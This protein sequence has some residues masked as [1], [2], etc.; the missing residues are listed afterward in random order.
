MAE[1][2][3]DGCQ[4]LGRE[5]E[6]RLAAGFEVNRDT[7]QFM[8]S[9][10]SIETPADLRNLLSDPDG[11]EAQSLI[12]LLFTPDETMRV[13]LEEIIE[14]SSCTN[15]D[16]AAIINRLFKKKMAV[17]IQFPG[18]ADAPVCRPSRPLLRRW[19]Q[20]FRITTL[21]PAELVA[22]IDRNFAGR[23][24]SQVK[25]ALRNT[26]VPL[27]RPLCAFVGRLVEKSDCRGQTF[28]Q[29]LDLCLAIIGEQPAAASFYDLFMARKRRLRVM[30]DQAARFEKQ[31]AEDNIETLILKGVRTPHIDK[32]DAR[33]KITRI[34][35][36]CLAVFGVTDPL[37]QIPARSDLGNFSSRDDLDRAF[38]IL[39]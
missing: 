23:E 24:R 1:C 20:R 12:E 29:N 14:K 26:R 15:E 21:L 25:A 28:L 34:D 22:V 11:S 13:D 38:E 35:T 8:A 33:D 31:L 6:T 18:I 5:M 9:T 7:R 36:V 39:S 10:F 32:A 17:S 3:I 4:L 37:L 16:E 19:V 2:L 30:L 27:S